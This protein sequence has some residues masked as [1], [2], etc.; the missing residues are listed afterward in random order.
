M[1]L[2]LMEIYNESINCLLDPSKKNL[3]V[4]EEPGSQRLIIEGLREET[5]ASAD[6]ALVAVAR[7]ENH[8]KVA[9]TSF[10]EDSSR[11]HTICKLT[12]KV[13][14]QVEAGVGSG[15][16]S[17]LKK[18]ARANGV[19][20]TSATLCLI[21]LAGSESAKVTSTKAR[22]DEGGFINKSLLTLGTVINKLASGSGSLH[23]PFRD[24][25]L[26]HA[27]KDIFSPY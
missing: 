22:R 15:V 6:D 10:N 11:S 19:V 16:G 21:D 2:S 24:S 1:K 12:I 20:T 14:R 23:I 25:K 3:R 27:L 9:S 5:V 4:M 26:T 17:N 18:S 8:R 13:T 7:G